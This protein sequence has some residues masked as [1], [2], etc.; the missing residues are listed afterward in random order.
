[1]KIDIFYCHY[2]QILLSNNWARLIQQIPEFLHAPILRYVNWSD[3]QNSLLSRLLLKQALIQNGFSP[4]LLMQYPTKPHQR[5]QLSPLFDINLSHSQHAA[6]CAISLSGKIGIDIEYHRA[7][8][9]ES[10]QR[11]FTAQQW[12]SLQ[13]KKTNNLPLFYQFWTLKESVAKAD[14]RGLGIDLARIEENPAGQVEIDRHIWFVQSLALKLPYYSCYLASD[15]QAEIV[16]KEYSIT[17]FL[18]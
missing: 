14:G 11:I 6:I 13:Q 5:P 10:F 4:D 3:R 1:M 12:H 9:V 17:D 8:E 16:I 2:P 18:S 15:H 7:L